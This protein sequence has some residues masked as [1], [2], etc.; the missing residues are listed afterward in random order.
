[1]KSMGEGDV[2]GHPLEPYPSPCNLFA[3]QRFVVEA[4]LRGGYDL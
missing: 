3:D 4:V 2:R 1:M